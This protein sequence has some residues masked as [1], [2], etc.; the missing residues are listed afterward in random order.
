LVLT[1]LDGT[2]RGGIAIEVVERFGLPIRYLGLGE[3]LED[4]E[5]FSADDFAR[6]LIA[7]DARAE[8]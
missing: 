8:R 5:P 6:A 2:A 4:L 7:P 1:K 3:G